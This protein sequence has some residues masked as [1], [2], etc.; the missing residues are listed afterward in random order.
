[1]RSRFWRARLRSNV[2]RKPG[3]A[4][5]R[6]TSASCSLIDFAMSALPVDAIGWSRVARLASAWRP[7]RDTNTSHDSSEALS[8]GITPARM[9][10]DLPT[11]D[12]AMTPTSG[13]SLMRDTMWVTSRV[14]PKKRSA[15]VSWNAV[16]PGK[17]FSPSSRRRP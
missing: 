15:S 2:P 14:R 8:A 10:D 1:M 12:G 5:S 13:W 6:A 16:M 17:G 9:N 11:P 7:G 4:R 3:S